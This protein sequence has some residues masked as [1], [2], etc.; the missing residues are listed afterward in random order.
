MVIKLK[1]VSID[2]NLVNLKLLEAISKGLDIDIKSFTNPL[3]AL[4]YIKQN[5]TDLI[6]VDYMMPEMHGIDFIKHARVI[7]PDI[8]IIMIT[9]VADDNTVKLQ[10]IE[11]GATEFLYK[12]LN[13]AE[14]RARVA[15]VSSLRKAQIML[16]D[17]ALLL[18][19]EVD[20]A[21]ALIRERE[22]EALKILSFAAE[23]KDPDTGSHISRVALYSAM[24]A[25]KLGETEENIDLIFYA[26]PLH[27]IGKIA[28]PDKI[29]TKRG[30]LTKEEFDI[31][32]THCLK[33][34]LM[35]KDARN[36]YL[37]AGAVVALSHHEKYNG[38]G[39]PNGL[40]GDDIPLFGRI[41]AIADVFDAVM[42][43][44]PYKEAW[45]MEKALELIDSQRGLHFDPKV[46]DVFLAGVDEVKKIH[47]EYAD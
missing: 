5:D 46:V 47:A 8:P 31:M 7:Y 22:H 9:A 16:K 32:K 17:R 30:T 1:T 45:P 3:V 33:G 43:R 15:N 26:A 39:Y 4:E 20:K 21:T 36:P 37:K 28:I 2:D 27:D 38:L 19:D 10:A 44:R 41:V 23:Y 14:F 25:R 18:Q 12:P 35:L 29:L 34:Y 13:P 24:V 6:F 11:A 40:R 42:S